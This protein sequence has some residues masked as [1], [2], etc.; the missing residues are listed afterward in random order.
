MGIRPPIPSAVDVQARVDAAVAGLVAGAPAALN[1][2]DEL[3]AALADDANLAATI[4]AALA[5][6][7]ATADASTTAWV[8]PT[9]LS[10]WVTNGIGFQP[11]RYRKWLG[12]VVVEG[13]ALNGTGGN[14]A[15][16]DEL[17]VLPAGFCPSGVI[18]NTNY[19]KPVQVNAGGEVASNDN[20]A[21][22]AY[23]GCAIVFVPA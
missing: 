3:A 7:V 22:G 14:L 4:T 1:T 6:K 2:L 17:F 11:P 5:G 20:T 12:L 19:G 10:G 16:T 13:L 21:A 23:F 18:I 15:A 8:T 9:L